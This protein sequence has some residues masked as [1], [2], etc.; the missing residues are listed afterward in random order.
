[1]IRKAYRFFQRQ[2]LG[3]V[4]FRL[5]IEL[6]GLV[7]PDVVLSGSRLWP[8]SRLDRPKQLIPGPLPMKK[9]ILGGK[10]NGH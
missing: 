2:G 8:V 4:L 7:K 6:Y 1:M 10:I 3:G 9:I 5:R